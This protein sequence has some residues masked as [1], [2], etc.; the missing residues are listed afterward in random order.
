MVNMVRL[1]Q[2]EHLKTYRRPGTWVMIGIL[3][4]VSIAFGFLYQMEHEGAA[5]DWRAGLEK[6]NRQD[7][8]TLQ[9]ENLNQMTRANVE[10]RYQI[11]QYRLDHNMPPA[12][13]N[14][15]GMMSETAALMSL[16]T[17]FTIIVSATSVAG[18][19]SQG[20]IKLL[21]IRPAS[22]AKILL[23]KYLSSFGLALT[24]LVLAFTFSFITGLIL[25]GNEGWETPHLYVQGGQVH[26]QS[27][28]LHVIGLYGLKGVDLL[29]MTTF[30]FMISVVFRSS[31]LAIG[32]A[33]FLMF[34]GSNVVMMLAAL[35]YD[36]VKYILFANT[37]L[38]PYFSGRPLVEGMTLSFS[39]TVLAVYFLL[40]NAISWLVFHKRDVAA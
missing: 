24:L 25:F 36:W 3:L 17:L 40:F 27:M 30:A 26:E 8:K 23:A 20:T 5:G 12:E 16:V 1:M 19:F 39:V 34:T 22:R 6:Q 7:E 2:N 9:N 37:D 10:E 38:S 4:L 29:M 28:L 11:N 14:L 31:A 15:W 33:L 32:L 13:G 35:G 18:E 21:L